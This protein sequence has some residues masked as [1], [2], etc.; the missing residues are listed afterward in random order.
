MPDARSRRRATCAASTLS[1]RHLADEPFAGAPHE[2]PEPDLLQ[3]ALL[4]QVREGLVHLAARDG[5]H[6]EG[7]FVGGA[8]RGVEEAHARKIAP[9]QV[10]EDD[11]ELTGRRLGEDEITECTTHLVAHQHRILT[12][13]A[14]LH[15][16]HVTEVHARDLA[17]ELGD[18]L[19]VGLGHVAAHARAELLLAHDERLGAADACRPTQHA[20]EE[21]EGRAFAH[22]VTAR[23]P[24][25]DAR[26]LTD[27]PQELTG[28]ARLAA[29]A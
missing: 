8:E 11:H 22:R 5:E 2:R 25:L 14:E 15:A 3:A 21:A 24:R 28:H 18:T 23:L 1:P 6:H 20:R 4:P 19:H 26:E 12:G 9:V 27:A 16:A 29:P 10:F 7:P 17:D 13:R